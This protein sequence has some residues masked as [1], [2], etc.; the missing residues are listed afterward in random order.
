MGH[1]GRPLVAGPWLTSA[2]ALICGATLARVAG[3]NVVLS[4][5]NGVDLSAVL[6]TL[7]FVAYLCRTGPWLL[8]PKIGR[9]AASKS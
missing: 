6:W 4:G 5:L 9:K 2:F 1:T 8:S 3:Q 7:A